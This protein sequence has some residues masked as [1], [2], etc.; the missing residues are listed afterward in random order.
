MKSTHKVLGPML[1][2][3]I[4]PHTTI[5]E[6][7]ARRQ[8]QFSATISLLILVMLSFQI[9]VSLMT[10]RF[11]LGITLA[12]LWIGVVL[13]YGL[14]RT[15]SPQWGSVLLVLGFTLFAFILS[16]RH[17][18]DVNTTLYGM[19]PIAY[20]L[21]SVLLSVRWQV[22]LVVLVMAGSVVLGTMQTTLGVNMNMLGGNLVALGAVLI[23]TS[24]LRDG[25]ERR[26]LDQLR[27][28]NRELETTRDALDRERNLLLDSETRTRALLAAIPDMIFELSHDGVFLDFM[29]SQMSRPFLQPE[30]FLGRNIAEVMPPEIA[31]VSLC[32]VQQALAGAGMQMFEYQLSFGDALHDYEAR[33]VTSRPDAVLAIVRDITNRKRAEQA[34][35]ES[36]QMLRLVFER[37]FDGISVYEEF[38]D[39][40]PRKLL[41]C[42]VRYAEIAGCS[43]DDLLHIGNTVPLQTTIEHRVDPDKMDPLSGFETYRGRF[44]WNRP[45]GREN[46]VEYA[47][48]RIYVQNRTLVIGIDRD[49]TQQMQATRERETLVTDLEAKNAELERFTYTVSHDLKSPLITIGGFV[50]F[51]ERDALAGNV[52]RMQADITRI[53]DAVARMQRLLGELL[54]LSRI[55]RKMNPPEAIAFE[56]IVR[57][58]VALVQGRI[59]TGGVEVE[60]APSLPTV[61][62]DRTRLVE[63]VQ[64]LVDNAVKFMGDQ[65]QPR[66]AVGARQDGEQFVFYVSD[67]GMGIAPQYQDKVFGLFEKLDPNSEGTGIGL[68]IVKRIIET[69]GGKIWAESEGAGQGS[70]FCFTL[71]QSDKAIL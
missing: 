10:N 1:N 43:K 35:H 49:I 23:F 25:I 27:Q 41:N 65:P 15:K 38:A 26:R 37:A 58:A 56:V 36:E 17:A 45:D 64:N 3:L 69:H 52:E 9:S 42:N 68:A 66:V 67:N 47:A 40:S 28:I 31:A 16:G 6:V 8:A 34:L 71:P 60:I 70:T 5:T 7:G 39:G 19:I 24:K 62:G 33:V 12:L 13:V 46:I 29:P 2:R 48:V 50:G 61:Y 44:S 55:G 63:A 59:A 30:Y 18:A 54:E 22:V 20:V 51:L 21:A 57:E 11:E 4:A 32:A 53:N 14:S